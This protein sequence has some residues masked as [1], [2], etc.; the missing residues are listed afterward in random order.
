MTFDIENPRSAGGYIAVSV[1]NYL[2]L[3]CRAMVEGMEIKACIYYKNLPVDNLKK[4]S[5]R[6][7]KWTTAESALSV[8]DKLTPEDYKEI[9]WE[10]RKQALLSLGRP[11]GFLPGTDKPNIEPERE[12]RYERNG[13]DR[14][15]KPCR[16]IRIARAM[17]DYRLKERIA[18]G[19]ITP[20][21]LIPIELDKI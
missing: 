19:K 9:V 11:F 18:G 21:M 4:I 17:C 2:A 20:A 8:F 10:A 12:C 13:L 7:P 3:V 16:A 1:R 5:R 14:Y 15:C 6:Y